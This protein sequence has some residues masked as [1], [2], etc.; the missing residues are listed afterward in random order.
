MRTWELA[1]ASHVGRGTPFDCTFGGVRARDTGTAAG[2]GNPACQANPFPCWQVAD[3]RGTTCAHGSVMG[4]PPPTA[5]VIQL[6]RTPTVAAIPPGDTNALVARDDMGNALGG[7][8]TPAI[9]APVGAYYGT[10]TCNPASLGSWLACSCPMTQPPSPSCIRRT[11]PTLPRVTASANKA[12]ADGFMLQDD[13]QQLSPRPMQVPLVSWGQRSLLDEA[14]SGVNNPSRLTLN[15]R[16]SGC[17]QSR[18]NL[19]REQADRLV[20]PAPALVAE[21]LF[22]KFSSRLPFTGRLVPLEPAGAF[23]APPRLFGETRPLSRNRIGS[24]ACRMPYA[25]PSRLL[26]HFR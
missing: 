25:S 7:I 1:G 18:H 10:N 16:R 23:S 11:T 26:D 5:P 9:D 15:A 20:R 13:A 17:Q 22:V 6:T 2:P 4:T 24:D 21:G 3:A 14:S 19:R 8:R 12:I